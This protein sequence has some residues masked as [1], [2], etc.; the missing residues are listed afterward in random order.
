[1]SLTSTS[2]DEVPTA[3]RKPDPHRDTYTRTQPVTTL[4]LSMSLVPLSY[5]AEIKLGSKLSR[6]YSNTG[7]F[8]F[9]PDGSL[10]AAVDEGVI[11]KLT[12]TK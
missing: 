3:G 4:S 12:P 8:A 1:M 2:D 10:Y 9:G 6:S 5:L 11:H 7:G